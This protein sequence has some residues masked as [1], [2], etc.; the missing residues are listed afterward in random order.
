MLIIETKVGV[1]CILEIPEWYIV[2]DNGKVDEKSPSKWQW[3]QH[4]K[5]IVPKWGVQGTTNNVRSM[6]SVGDTPQSVYN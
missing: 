5:S 6:F 4:H 1:F 3:S 2:M